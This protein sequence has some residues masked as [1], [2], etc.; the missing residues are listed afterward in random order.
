MSLS[1][2]LL[3]RSKA[4]IPYGAAPHVDLVPPAERERRER[5]R[6]IR[7]W[8]AGAIVALAVI[9]L[10]F[11]GATTLEMQAEQELQAERG[12]TQDLTV[13]L[14][15]YA[16][17]AAAVR[18][19]ATY[20]DGLAQAM[21]TDVEWEPLYRSL[22]QRMPGGVTVTAFDA[23]VLDAASA[24]PGAAA[25]APAT[26]E[27]AATVT[28]GTAVTVT[29]TVTSKRPLDQTRMSQA[30]RGIKS[31]LSVEMVLLDSAEPP[32]YLYTTKVDFGEQVYSQRFTGEDG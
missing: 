25:P 18:S 32:T 22:A 4:K 27:E 28:P 12:R 19:R 31:A 16:D 3:R 7:G 14:A 23:T 5:R 10:A 29:L 24:D 2:P 8:V 21:R 9:A 11:A 30:F 13:E 1:T 26:G 17:V 6:L 20:E 15:E